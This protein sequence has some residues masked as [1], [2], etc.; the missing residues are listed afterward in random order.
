MVRFTSA[1]SHFS[2]VNS[3]SPALQPLLLSTE[4]ILH[5]CS[6]SGLIIINSLVTAEIL[7]TMNASACW[8][9]VWNIS[10]LLEHLDK[11][12]RSRRHTTKYDL[13]RLMLDSSGFLFNTEVTFSSNCSSL[14]MYF[15]TAF[16]Y[17]LLIELESTLHVLTGTQ[18]S[19]WAHCGKN[20]A[21]VSPGVRWTLI[22][23]RVNTKR[24]CNEECQWDIH[25]HLG[26]L[27]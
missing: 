10:I 4:L 14:F 6:S 18:V 17:D 16:L 21:N 8:D 23:W 7:Q 15:L 12:V 5:V 20:W 1:W 19:R 9:K 11:Q 27:F 24:G 25:R 2:A 3:Q 26:K 22:G 13:T